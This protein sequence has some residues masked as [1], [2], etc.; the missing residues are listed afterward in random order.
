MPNGVLGFSDS[1]VSIE[2]AIKEMVDLHHEN[3]SMI[4]IM[5]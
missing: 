4:G 2:K 1:D 3:K 5:F